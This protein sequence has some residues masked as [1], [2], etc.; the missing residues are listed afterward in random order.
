MVEKLQVEVLDPPPGA[1]QD[2]Q[3]PALADS[4]PTD[5]N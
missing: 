2:E 5:A 1:D 4:R 3:T